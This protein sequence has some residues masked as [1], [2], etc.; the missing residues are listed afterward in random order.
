M[1]IYKPLI[2]I[3]STPYI[4][5]PN[6]KSFITMKLLNVVRKAGFK[7]YIIPYDLKKIEYNKIKK[8]IDGIIF[9]GSHVLFIILKNLYNIINLKNI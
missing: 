7:P 6:K 4:G 1:N 3:L 5:K 8:N 2:G 9:P